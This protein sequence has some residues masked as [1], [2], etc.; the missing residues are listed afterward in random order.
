[1]TPFL[2]LISIAAALALTG[3]VAAQPAA[4]PPA[5]AAQSCFFARNIS[6]WREAGD[7]IVNLRVGVRDIYQLKLLGHCPDLHWAEAIGIETRSG[8]D[9]VCSGLDVNIIIPG[10]VTHT[11][12]LRCMATDLRRLTPAEV[13]ALPPKQKP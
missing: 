1:M 9:H 8:S 10:S 3:S 4:A 2:R 7:Q 5:A 13:Q 11:V 12:P 6:N